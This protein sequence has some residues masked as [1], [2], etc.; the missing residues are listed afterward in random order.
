MARPPG[1][2]WSRLTISF[3][4]EIKDQR[5][6]YEVDTNLELILGDA[7]F[8]IGSAGFLINGYGE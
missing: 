6:G 7:R 4:R 1:G 2:S 8:R 5:V 3:P